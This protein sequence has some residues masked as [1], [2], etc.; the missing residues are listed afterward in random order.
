[1]ASSLIANALQ[2][3]FDSILGFP[4]NEGM[5]NMFKALESTGLRG[6]LGSPS[7]IYEKALKRFFDTASVRENEIIS[8]VLGKFVGI[9]E[10]Q[11][12]DLLELL[13]TGLT[14]MTE[15][16]KDL[17]YDARSIFSESGNVDKS[18]KQAKGFAAQIYVFLKS[19]TNLSLVEA[20]T[21]PPQKIL[22]VKIVGTYVSKNK[23]IGSDKDEPEESV[24]KKTEIKRIPAHVIVEPVAKKK[25]TTMGRAAPAEKGLAMIPVVQ[26][27]EPIAIVPAATP[28]SQHH[29]EPKRKL[30]LQK[31]SDD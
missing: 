16:P 30:V 4:N 22:T 7:V 11:F 21:F 10:E 20:K 2:V 12:A 9:S 15:V 19:A 13:M 28:K 6:F 25:R 17:V 3:N 27:P 14:D 5:V 31:G 1:M 24:S 23:N 26:D 18:S 8:A 29:R